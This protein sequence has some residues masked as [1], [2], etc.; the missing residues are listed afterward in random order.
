MLLPELKA[1][2]LMAD[3][4]YDAEDRVL[5]LM[6]KAGKIAVVPPKKNRLKTRE[7]DRHL[8]KARSLIENFFC[9]LKQFRGIA[10][11]HVKL[12]KTSLQASIL[13]LR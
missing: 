1:D 7:Y 8:Y 11:R 5:N 4:A 13:L 2:I 12:L 9:K 10:T 6:R 3:K